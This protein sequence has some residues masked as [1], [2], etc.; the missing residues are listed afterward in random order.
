MP[1]KKRIVWI[2]QLKGLAFY[3][4]ILGHL[5]IPGIAIIWIYSFHMPLFFMITGLNLDLQKVRE[6][7]FK[8][9]FLKLSEKILVPYFWLQMF[10]FVPRFIVSLVNG[11]PVQVREY[12]IGILAGNSHIADAPSN[13]LYYVLLL[14]LAQLSLWVCIRAVNG[15]KE[16]LGVLLCVLSLASVFTQGVHLPWHIN[17]VPVAMLFIFAG[18][19]LMD[20]YTANEEKISKAGFLTIGSVI[21]I[22]IVAG[23]FLG[24]F[25]GKISIHSNEYG[26]SFVL[27][28]IT[29]TITSVALM[30]A[31]MKLPFNKALSFIG[32]N[33]FFYMGIHKPVLLIA[34]SFASRREEESLVFLLLTSVICYVG[35]IPV[36]MLFEKCFPYA[37]GKRTLKETKLFFLCKYIAITLCGFVPYMYLIEEIVGDNLIFK[38]SAWILFAVIVVASERVLTKLMPFMFLQEKKVS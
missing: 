25:N 27:F 6:T 16:H 9:Y 3:T 11:R 17:V 21:M 10:S 5:S 36:T 8:N 26:K 33:T 1:E 29:A 13:P 19:L 23:F 20:F 2:D 12:L 32:K 4:V 38:A 35:L 7:T 37:C 15:K 14:F 30:L 18:R 24:F 22:F 31:V 34:E 28:F